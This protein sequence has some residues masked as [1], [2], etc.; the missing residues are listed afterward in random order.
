MCKNIDLTR[1]SLLWENGTWEKRTR[2]FIVEL[3]EATRE[4]G[5]DGHFDYEDDGMQ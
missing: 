1:I 2:S 3:V 5:E 4:P